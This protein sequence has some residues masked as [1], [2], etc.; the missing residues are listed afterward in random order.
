MFD[1]HF[2]VVKFNYLLII[3]MYHCMYVEECYSSSGWN[4]N[5]QYFSSNIFKTC[6]SCTL[7]HFN[8]LQLSF[9]CYFF[10]LSFFVFTTS[11]YISFL[12]LCTLNLIIRIGKW[13]ILI[14]CA[15][16]EHKNCFTFFYFCIFCILRFAKN[17]CFNLHLEGRL[18]FFSWKF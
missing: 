4:F 7:H 6:V 16:E 15:I 18:F 14:I 3:Y 10:F 8:W 11:L 17:I 13:T 12:N 2:T 5:F 9:A 1:E